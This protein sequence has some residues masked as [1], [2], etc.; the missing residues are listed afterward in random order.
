VG[1]WPARSRAA[2]RFYLGE[3]G[4]VQRIARRL[5]GRLLRQWEYAGLAGAPDDA[6][7]ELGT[8][9]GQLY[10][11][12][13]DPVSNRYR[14]FNFARRAGARLVIINEG[15]CIQV[16]GMR[17]KG[18]GLRI[19]HRQLENATTLGVDRIELIAG[20]CNDEHGYYTWPRFGFD[21]PLPSTV[22]E[23]L[24]LGLE[25]VSSVL[26]LMECEK[27]RLWWRENGCTIR[28]TFDLTDCSRSRAVF[29][30]YV[31]Q[32]LGIRRVEE[33]GS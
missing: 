20:R 1:L 26:D 18:L 28:V 5:F 17:R 6:C 19:F 25:H 3:R 13:S 21:G 22:K 10:V 4:D 12:T 33:A 15:F 14:T 8:C 27:G 16:E 2:V 11:E 24:P 30:R 7:V 29:R 32:R 23:N 9:D 31:G